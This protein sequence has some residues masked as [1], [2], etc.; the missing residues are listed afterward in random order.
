MYDVE[1]D[2]DKEEELES[3]GLWLRLETEEDL[4]KGGENLGARVCS[5]SLNELVCL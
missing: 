2:S 4:I 3:L 5:G 1:A